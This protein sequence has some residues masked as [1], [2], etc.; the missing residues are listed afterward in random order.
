MCLECMALPVIAVATPFM[1]NIYRKLSMTKKKI[2]IEGNRPE[3]VE[4][5]RALGYEPISDDNDLDT[6]SLIVFDNVSDNRYCVW[7]FREGCYYDIPMVGINNGANFLNEM[8]GGGFENGNGEHFLE[9]SHKI[10]IRGLN[11]FI[12]SPSKHHNVI[13]PSYNEDCIVLADTGTS[14]E[15]VYYSSTS[16]LCFQ[17]S[18]E[19][20][21]KD[22][23]C[24]KV[25]TFFMN[26]Y[27]EA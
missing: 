17:P 26:N 15:A 12:S 10:H 14:V 4:M 3:M 18:V 24:F 7:L 27:L 16:C 6:A 25:F 22:S 19:L 5:F 21:E 20:C 1:Y 8:N 9:N 13:I 2:F 11:K 23:E